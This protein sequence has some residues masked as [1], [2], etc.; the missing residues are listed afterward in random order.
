MAPPHLSSISHPFSSSPITNPN[1][2][3]TC[4][5]PLPL[6]SQTLRFISNSSSSSS[7][8]PP[9]SPPPPDPIPEK[10]SLAVATGELFLGLAARLIKRSSD[11][12]SNSVSMF[13]NRTGNNRSVYEERIGAVVED[14]IQ[15]GVLWEQRVKDVEAERER[16]LVTSPGF[17]FSAAGLLFPYH[18][19]VA[20]FLLENSYIKETTP[21]AGASAG[22]IVC[23]V[24]ASGASM[25]EALQ[26]TKL[27]AEDCRSRG[28]AFRL[29]AVLREVLDK[30]LPDDVH[31][32]CNGRVR[33]A[34][35]QVFWR[36]RGLLVDQFDSKDD[37]IDAVFTSSFIPG[38]LAPRP[39]TVFRNRLC[40][41]GGLTLFMP[42][43]SASQTVRVCAFPASRL[44]FE[45]I[46]IS[47][48]CNPE[49]RAGPRELFNWALEPAEDDI[50]DKLF[51]LGY[52][53]AAV[54]GED[55]PVEKLVEDEKHD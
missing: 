11:Q 7:P 33:V 22:A 3:F 6:R 52:E 30:F 26:A 32:R 35:T 5:F 53:D 31:I 39:V 14:E 9:P 45:G 50:L 55:N 54:W 49:N 10:R 44:G 42:P 24:I 13:D 17:S 40:I 12:T 28:T 43:T 1:L 4:R 27:L 51:E 41:D 20:K 34:V 23:A 19:G 38:Y 15:P 47:P 36:P 18:L 46:G 48:D 29:G 8:P 16:P 37:L 25:Q 21:L 2:N